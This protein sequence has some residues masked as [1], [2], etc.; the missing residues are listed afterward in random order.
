MSWRAGLSQLTDAIEVRAGDPDAPV[1]LTCEHATQRMPL[2]W[3]WPAADRRLVDTHWAFDLGARGITR[4]LSGAMSAP[5][6]LSRF[7]RLLIDPNRP[8]R[9]SPT[10]FRADAEGLPVALNTAH[11]DEPERRRRIE[12]LWRPYHEAIDRALEAST[13]PTVLAIHTFT[14]LYEG[15]PRT[16][17]IGVLFD[18]DQA[19]AEEVATT[20]GSRW[21]VRMNEPYS[22]Q[23]GLMF[24]AESHARAHGRRAVELEIRQDLAVDPRFR[25][26]LVQLLKAH[27]AR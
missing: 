9:G 27:F 18:G 10:L 4:A 3:R 25:D 6:V 19:L 17:E 16:V 7:S 2:G 23:N 20:L 8:E 5:A 13:A 12:H 26:D 24:A 15:E 14:P 21:H 11:L 22:G 1:V